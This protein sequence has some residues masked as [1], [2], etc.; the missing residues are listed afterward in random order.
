MKFLPTLTIL[1]ASL[2]LYAAA[3]QRESSYRPTAAAV[4]TPAPAAATIS[5]GASL[6]TSTSQIGGDLSPA[7]SQVEHDAQAPAG[8]TIPPVGAFT[9]D[10]LWQLRDFQV[11]HESAAVSPPPAPTPVGAP[12][13]VAMPAAAY[14]SY[15]PTYRPTFSGYYQSSCGPNGC[16]SGF[17]VFRRGR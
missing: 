14:T 15:Y 3:D 4:I 11:A 13:P 9:H 7:P 1:A 16:S 6:G 8:A 2:A 10:E 5:A 17:R 12:V